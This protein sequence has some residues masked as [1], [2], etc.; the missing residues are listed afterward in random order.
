M[1]HLYKNNMLN[2]VQIFK[3]TQPQ[4]NQK[5]Q[6]FVLNFEGRVTKPSVKNFQIS[7]EKDN[8]ILQ[9][10][11]VDENRFTLDFQYPLS[12]IQAFC[13]ALSAFDKKL[14]CE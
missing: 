3:N 12:P 1:I 2:N 6:A 5:L 8:I 11:K 4:W 7:D 13:I 10:G 14:A 9:F